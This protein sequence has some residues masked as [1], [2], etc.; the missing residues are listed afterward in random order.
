M[1]VQKRGVLKKLGLCFLILFFLVVVLLLLMQFFHGI[2]GTTT[3]MIPKDM[4]AHPHVVSAITVSKGWFNH[5][6]VV[7]NSPVIYASAMGL[8]PGAGQSLYR[9]G[10]GGKTWVPINTSLVSSISAS[11]AAVVYVGSLEFGIGKTV[12]G[13]KTWAPGGL[14]NTRIIQVHA[15][16][17]NTVYA[18]IKDKYTVN[19]GGVFKTTDGG[20]HWNKRYFSNWTKPV[21]LYA[22]NKNTV[23]VGL[24]R[25]FLENSK[26]IKTSDGGASW[27]TVFVGKENMEVKHLYAVDENTLFVATSTG[28]LKT[29]DGGGSWYLSTSNVQTLFK[30]GVTGI[31]ARDS[32]TVYVACSFPYSVYAT[33]NGGA[34]WQNIN[35]GS[36]VNAI[37]GFG[38][39]VYIGTQQGLFQLKESP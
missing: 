31:Y 5:L 36:P 20:V 26:I 37:S 28:I 13:G 17:P 30:Y 22:V 29:L 24:Q 21:A 8:A 14:K 18:L 25:G 35:M 16:D 10:N 3:Q 1:A 15:V 19:G 27:S 34:A 32:Q 38:N 4:T 23:Y 39:T 9:S 11:N 12:D 33:Y 6:S 2:R 7:K